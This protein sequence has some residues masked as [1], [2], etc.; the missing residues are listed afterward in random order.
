MLCATLPAGSS[1]MLLTS[2]RTSTRGLVCEKLSITQ[3]LYDIIYGKSIGKKKSVDTDREGSL[4]T[5]GRN[6]VTMGKDW[7]WTIGLTHN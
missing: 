3:Q 2:Y 5:F 7:L 4:Q 1:L 6:E